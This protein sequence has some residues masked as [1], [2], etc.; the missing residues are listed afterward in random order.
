VK[1]GSRDPRIYPA[2]LPGAA[3]SLLTGGRLTG[4]LP[5]RGAY[6]PL[7]M[8]PYLRGPRASAACFGAPTGL[9]C[10]PQRCMHLPGAGVPTQD[11]SYWGHPLCESNVPVLGVRFG[12]LKS[13]KFGLVQ[14]L[15][16]A[17]RTRRLVPYIVRGG[18]WR[19]CQCQCGIGPTAPCMTRAIAILG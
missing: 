8:W 12:G 18:Q 13:A 15:E 4:E 9:A 5:R 7:D 3:N 6:I 1:T 2:F 19:Q 10:V 17:T 11:T 16:L 14:E